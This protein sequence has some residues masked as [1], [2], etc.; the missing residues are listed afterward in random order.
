MSD[1]TDFSDWAS[2]QFP[3]LAELDSLL[4][5]FI[6]KDFLRAPV[7]TSCGH[8]FC[9]ACVRK[10]IFDNAKCPLC[11]TEQYESG[12]KRSILL[13]EIVLCFLKQRPDLLQVL[14]KRIRPKADAHVYDNTSLIVEVKSDEITDDWKEQTSVAVPFRQEMVECPVCS[15][16]MSA[17]DL[18][19]EHID[20]CLNGDTPPPKIQKRPR[21]SFFP[22]SATP[23][24]SP[25]S[26]PSVSPPPTEPET[27]N[28]D[29]YFNEAEK[30]AQSSESRK[31]PKLNY[32]ALN[33]LKLKEKLQSLGISAV[34][35]RPQLEARYNEYYILF[36]SN[37]DSSH[38]ASER[39]L[40]H[41]LNQ[42]EAQQTSNGNASSVLSMS[43]TSNARYMNIESKE[44]DKK[45]WNWKYSAE[46]RELIEQAKEH[47]RRKRKV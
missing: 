35:T 39:E 3:G 12:L 21:S 42:W 18:Q 22:K 11:Q 27:T 40:R 47:A 37:L 19:T 44:F 5:C 34:G 43:R 9:S 31:L 33:N 15:S 13:E 14:Q 38:P 20:Y 24:K 41:K 7:L 16:I 17:E 46:Y 28:S 36:N 45:G 6:C 2:T 23:T 1:V 30:H 25:P 4:R 26:V 32:M 8:T 10:Y 29:F